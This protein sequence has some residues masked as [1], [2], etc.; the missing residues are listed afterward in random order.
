MTTALM[1]TP[2]FNSTFEP[3]SEVEIDQIIGIHE[4]KLVVLDISDNKYRFQ[5]TVSQT[6]LK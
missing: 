3:D 6:I 2:A 5:P 4:T 1:T